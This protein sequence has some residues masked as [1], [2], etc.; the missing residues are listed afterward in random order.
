LCFRFDIVDI[1][2]RAGSAPT[3]GRQAG[4][5]VTDI[6]TAE[7]GQSPGTGSAPTVGRQAGNIVTDVMTPGPGQ[8]PGTGSAPTVGRQAG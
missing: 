6:M 2:T 7:P 3:V 4:N 1:T 5:I 8:S